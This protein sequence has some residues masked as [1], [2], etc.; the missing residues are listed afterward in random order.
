M[1]VKTIGRTSKRPLIGTN[2]ENHQ[3]TRQNEEKE[4]AKDK[5]LKPFTGNFFCHQDVILI[6]YL[7]NS[8]YLQIVLTMWLIKQIISIAK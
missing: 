3:V 8:I 6:V 2:P 1:Y 4:R 5:K 7:A